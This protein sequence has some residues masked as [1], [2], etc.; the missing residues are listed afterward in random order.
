[1]AGWRQ[2]SI[3]GSGGSGGLL[4][5]IRLPILN[6][7]IV[8]FVSKLVLFNCGFPHHCYQHSFRSRIALFSKGFTINLVMHLMC[9]IIDSKSYSI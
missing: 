4:S 5:A 7:A 6:Y 9:Y 3:G 1:M 2:E 8:F